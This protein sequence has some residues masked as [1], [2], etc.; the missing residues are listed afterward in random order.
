MALSGWAMGGVLAHAVANGWRWWYPEVWAVILTFCTLYYYLVG[1]YRERWGLADR[2]ERRHLLC[3]TAA[4]LV[5]A[6]SE[7]T[8]IHGISEQYLFSVHMLQ[9]VLLTMVMAPLLIAGTPP[10]LIRR[11]FRWP[12]VKPLLT[13]LTRP[14]IALLAFNVVNAAW[15]LPYFYQAPLITHWLHPVQHIIMVVTALMM[16]WPLLSEVPEL[17]RLS[18][19]GQ[20]I[21]I[22]LILLVQLPVFAGI[23]FS[24]SV[25]YE[26]YAAAPEIWGM[27]PLAD[28]QA[29]GVTMK[30]GSLIILVYFMGRAF[31]R[32]A[33]EEGARG[34]WGPSAPGPRAGQASWQDLR[35]S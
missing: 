29:A 25:F 12:G 9:H 15:H 14:I 23:T 21:Y 19:G 6:I 26:F 35:A 16:W 24:N 10:W 32:W 3:F 34:G 1:P 13:F 31:F 33:R 2:V 17:P 27:A 20:V 11:A 7:A 5:M 22:F 8:P 18:Y 30:L 4:M 28:Q